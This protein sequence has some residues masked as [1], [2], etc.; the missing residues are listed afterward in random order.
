MAM[1]TRQ[2]GNGRATT[3]ELDCSGCELKSGSIS[4]G[5]PEGGIFRSILGPLTEDVAGTLERAAQTGEPVRLI[6]STSQLE[7]ERIEVSQAEPGWV[8]LVGAVSV[9]PP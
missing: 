2:K 3:L 1:P 6:F 8:L 7:F 9:P 4:Y 5:G